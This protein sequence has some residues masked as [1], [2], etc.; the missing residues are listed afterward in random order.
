MLLDINLP[1]QSGFTLIEE[2]RREDIAIPTI[3]LTGNALETNKSRGLELGGDDYIMKPF[4]YAELIAR[5]RA[6]LRRSE[7]CDDL[8][9]TKNARVSDQPFEVCG[10]TVHPG[11]LEIHFDDRIENI[12]R[13]ELG[14][15]RT[16]MHTRA[17]SSLARHLSIQFGEYMPM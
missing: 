17:S 9:V 4:G 1:D 14:S 10:G 11:R 5:I 13:K 6:V 2:L 3:F 16:S 7:S 8:K 15:S 12:G